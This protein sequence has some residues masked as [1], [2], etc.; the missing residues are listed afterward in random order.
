MF[1]WFPI[2]FSYDSYSVLTECNQFAKGDGMQANTL[3][4]QRSQQDLPNRV[5]P[6]ASSVGLPGIWCVALASDYDGTLAEDGRISEHVVQFLQKFR[7][8][9]RKLFLVTGRILRDLESVFSRF[10]LFDCIV[11][12]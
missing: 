3:A 1:D 10:D 9:G 4:E 6:S 7:R 12:E 2:L 8:S 5:L 11:A